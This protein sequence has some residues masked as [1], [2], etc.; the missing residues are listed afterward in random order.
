MGRSEPRKANAN[1]ARVHDVEKPTRGPIVIGAALTVGLT[2]V[3]GLAIAGVLLSRVHEIGGERGGTLQVLAVKPL[4]DLDPAR[5]STAF[6]ASLLHAT[7][8]TP[9]AFQPDRGIVSDLALGPPE[10][11]DDST[12]LELTLRPDVSFGPPVDR[13]VTA[14]D[15]VYAIERGFLPSVDSPYAQYYLGKIRGLHAFRTGKS[16]SISG[17]QAPDDDTLVI[18]LADP[19]ARTISQ[20]MTMPMT[21]PVPREYASRFDQKPESTYARHQV[22][23]GPYRFEPGKNGLIPGPDARAV[24]LVRNP[25]WDPDTD[26]RQAFLDRISVKPAPDEDVASEKVLH[27]QASVSGDFAASPDVLH[28]ALAKVPDQIRLTH[29]GVNV[30]I[31]LNTTAPPLDDVSVR[32]AVTAAFDQQG[33]REALGGPVV[34]KIPTH[35]IP[36]GVPG[37]EEAGGAEGPGF[38]FLSHPRGDLELAHDYMR[39]AGY[40]SGRYDGDQSLVAVGTDT[41]FTRDIAGSVRDAFR[42]LGIPIDIRIVAPERA[43]ALCSTVAT[44]PDACLNATWV[45]DFDDA[46]SILPPLFAGSNIRERGNSNRSLLDDETVNA[47]IDQAAITTGAAD[48]AENWAE[49]DKQVTSVAP[50]IPVV[51]D[52]Y[53]LLRSEDVKGIVDGELGRWDLSFTSLR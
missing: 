1:P 14:D 47:A 38:D 46:V 31:T 23:T 26:F 33:A 49:A 44:T 7:V 43:E 6:D 32:R 12:H 16:K 22:A 20:A 4:G 8:R 35:W 39:I 13:K 24:S 27:G 50:G 25:S 42:S 29:A 19:V 41:S 2:V 21:A 10:I 18:D 17:L 3:T 51:W 9:Y 28:E 48:R 36:P 53:P 11:S 45:K 40:P 52:Y 5:H 15:F 37:F 34:G 30:F